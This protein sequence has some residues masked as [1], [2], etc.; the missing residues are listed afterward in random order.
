[1]D[2]Q[3]YTSYFGNIKALKEHGIIPI[4]IARWLP[5][6]YNGISLKNVAPT[7]SMLKDDITRDEYIK[8]YNELLQ[9]IDANEFLETLKFF[10]KGQPCALICYEKPNEF[11]HRHLLAKYLNDKL[12]LNIEEFKVKEDIK[13]KENKPEELSLF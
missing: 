13:A 9:K 4:S 2:I 12:N 5:K 7:P 1:M 3:V 8:R 10:S 6:W 11:C